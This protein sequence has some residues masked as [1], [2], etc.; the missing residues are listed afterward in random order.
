V[1]QSE[2]FTL[3]VVA[4][5]LITIDEDAGKGIM[6]TGQGSNRDSE[7]RKNKTFQNQRQSQNSNK[8]E[9][10]CT[11]KQRNLIK[12]R[13]ICSI[14][15]LTAR[16]SSQQ[17]STHLVHSTL[18]THEGNTKLP[19]CTSQEGTFVKPKCLL[20]GYF[21][22]LRQELHKGFVQV[23]VGLNRCWHEALPMQ[24]MTTQTL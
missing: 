20:S 23:A 7:S 9:E 5:M 12:A 11:I 21:T 24:G 14:Y 1:L 18:T 15:K 10:L 6:T 17:P 22:E 3:S 16:C 8:L 19:V 2:L 4:L 13:N